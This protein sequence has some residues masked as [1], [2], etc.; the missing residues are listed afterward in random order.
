MQQLCLF[1]GQ[2]LSSRRGR[3]SRK[4]NLASAHAKSAQRDLWVQESEAEQEMVLLFL[5][6]RDFTPLAER[7][8]ATQ[9]VHLVRKLFSAFQNII[10]IHRGRII[11][12]MGDGFYAAFGINEDLSSAAQS[13]VNAGSAIL[14][15]LD[16]LNKESFETQLNRRIEIGIG[17]H[18][19]KVATG[20]LNLA[21]KNHFIVMGY[22][23]NIAAR[24]QAM[25]KELNNNLVVSSAVLEHIPTRASRS[26]RVTV[27]LKGVTDPLDV[28]LL[29]C[30]YFIQ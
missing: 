15:I 11:E 26:P 29:G 10:R 1:T 5:D 28:H 24:I 9:V 14:K 23:V 3:K 19:G 17:I 12:T 22:A 18:A 6:I 7:Q 16:R 25:T 8:E 30:P 2:T 13:A 21:D 27:N 4:Q 20:N